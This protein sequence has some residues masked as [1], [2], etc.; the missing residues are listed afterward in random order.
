M[1]LLGDYGRGVTAAFRQAANVT[2]RAQSGSFEVNH[3]NVLAA[4]KIIQSHVDL[5]DEKFV[6]HQPDL[7]V[8][9]AGLDQ[10]SI[11]LA[12]Q[13]NKR[14]LADD[15]SYA[16]RIRQYLDSL[17]NLVRKLE[18]SARTYGYSDQEIA[19]ALRGKAGAS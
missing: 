13:W 7:R 18:E 4:A 10:I 15:D 8:D 5:F 9:P 12:T 3:D 1:E 19:A 11:T 16:V 2:A 17:K 6:A 14:L